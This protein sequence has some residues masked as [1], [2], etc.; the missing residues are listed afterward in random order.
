MNKII[1]LLLKIL[2]PVICIATVLTI[3]LPGVSLNISEKSLDKISDYISDYEKADDAEKMVYEEGG[4]I[5]VYQ[6]VEDNSLSITEII[7]LH[8]HTGDVKKFTVNTKEDEI[9]KFV[10]KSANEYYTMIFI[11]ISLSVIFMVISS[12]VSVLKANKVISI[13]GLVS[14]GIYFCVNLVIL[15][16]INF[17]VINKL[18]ESSRF[19]AQLSFGTILFVCGA[20]LAVVLSFIKMFFVIRA[21]QKKQ[22]LTF[23][24][25]K[26]KNQDF[27]NTLYIPRAS[28]SDAKPKNTDIKQPSIKCI[29]GEYNGMVVTLKQTDKIVIG[30]DPLFAN[31]IITSPNISRTHCTVSYDEQEKKYI[32]VD[33]SS[34]GTY[35]ESGDKLLKDYPNLLPTGSIIYLGDKENV[36]QLGDC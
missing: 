23:Q 14:S 22:Y 29:K 12:A 21:E 5:N 30:R 34:N 13:T 4:R 33:K 18:N 3:F 32:V 36:F 20:F 28:D 10:V 9:Y 25:N 16:V 17:T 6:A 2:T 15:L 31:L 7:S 1:M 35:M 8:S 19:T 27:M 26:I 11:L 24:N